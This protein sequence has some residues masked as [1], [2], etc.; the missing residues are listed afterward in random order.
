MGGVMLKE[1]TFQEVEELADTG[2]WPMLVTAVE[3]RKYEPDYISGKRKTVFSAII[4]DNTI[5][6]VMGF[7]YGYSKRSGEMVYIGPLCVHEAYRG[8]GIGSLA[9]LAFQSMAIKQQKKLL[10]YAHKDVQGFYERHGFKAVYAVEED[11]QAMEWV[12]DGWEDK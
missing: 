10:L 5:V 1:I 2:K 8:C 4:K 7:E 11:Y 6:C 3:C 9:V 12:P